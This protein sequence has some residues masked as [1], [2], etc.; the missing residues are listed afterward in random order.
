MTT[1]LTYNEF[2]TLRANFQSTRPTYTK[3]L[4]SDFETMTR[5]IYNNYY[6]KG[7]IPQW[8]K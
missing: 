1:K 3:G 6:L 7:R 5:N 8:A 4:E 2:K